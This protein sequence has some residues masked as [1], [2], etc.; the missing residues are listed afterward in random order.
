MNQRLRGQIKTMASR[1][2]QVNGL[3]HTKLLKINRLGC[4]FVFGKLHY[5]FSNNS[6][7]T[8]TNFR[9]TYWHRCPTDLGNDAL[10]CLDQLYLG[11]GEKP[12]TCLSDSLTLG[13]SYIW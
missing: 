2:G 13:I 3:L 7:Q 11:A 10:I 4:C 1:L 6:C 12:A 5:N 9:N 8:F